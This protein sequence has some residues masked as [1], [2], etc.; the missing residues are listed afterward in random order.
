M[1]VMILGMLTFVSHNKV[2]TR[3]WQQKA[4]L[5]RGSVYKSIWP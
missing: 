4:A 3:L 2:G 5:I 1:I